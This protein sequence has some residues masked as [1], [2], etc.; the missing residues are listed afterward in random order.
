MKQ[1]IFLLLFISML[2]AKTLPE[3]SPS[4]GEK[5]QQQLLK[6]LTSLKKIKTHSSQTYMIHKG[7]N[8]FSTPKAGINIIQT[9]KNISDVTFIVT[10]DKISKYWAGFTLKQDVLKDLKEMLMLKYLEPNVSFFILSEKD[11]MLNVTSNRVNNTCK[12]YMKDKK[13]NFIEDSGIDNIPTYSSDNSIAVM[14]RYHSHFNRGFYD[15]TRIVLIYPN[16]NTDKKAEKKYGPAEPF[17]LVKY[18][19]EYK[20]RNFYIYDYLQE[21]CFKGVFP[22]RKMPPVPLLQELK[23]I[24]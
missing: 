13:Y 8:Q 11:L 1:F 15:D 9:F 18:A 14:P 22:S 21:K 16:I 2:P 4:F 6:K 7:W 10:Y 17:I 12:K 5:Q 23:N 19:S 24:N 3:V 20:N